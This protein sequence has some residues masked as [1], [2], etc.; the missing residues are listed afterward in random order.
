MHVRDRIKVTIEH[1]QVNVEVT[2]LLRW[3]RPNRREEDRMLIVVKAIVLKKYYGQKVNQRTT[4]SLRN[5]FAAVMGLL[6]T[7]SNLDV[8]VGT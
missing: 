7:L 6:M 4:E 2:D 5:D 8:K 3:V 1:G